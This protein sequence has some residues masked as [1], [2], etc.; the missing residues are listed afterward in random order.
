MADDSAGFD[1][2]APSSD[3]CVYQ[4]RDGGGF[5]YVQDAKNICRHAKRIYLSDYAMGGLGIASVI[6]QHIIDSGV[7]C[8]TLTHVAKTVLSSLLVSQGTV[9]AFLLPLKQAN[10]SIA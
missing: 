4:Q 7:D 6:V 9:V 3:Q 2:F 1:F 10:P 8:S 5:P